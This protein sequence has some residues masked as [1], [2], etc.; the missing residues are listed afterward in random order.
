MET[1]KIASFRIIKGN[2]HDTKWMYTTVIPAGNELFLILI[3]RA[4][5]I[6]VNEWFQN[7][8]NYTFERCNRHVYEE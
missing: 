5:F 8:F 4:A 3:Y 1:K 7:A 2:V 6:M